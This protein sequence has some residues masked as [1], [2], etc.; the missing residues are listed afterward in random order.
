MPINKI[1]VPETFYNENIEEQE[2]MINYI[3]G[4]KTI[5]IYTSDNVTLTKLRKLI[6]AKGSLY[7]IK[8]IGY[9]D[10]K[11]CC[12]TVAAP[13]NCLSFR[14]GQKRDLTDEQREALANRMR[15]IGKARK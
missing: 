7:E 11:P 5:E 13:L 12:M 14:A 2:T 6:E 4:D 15:A 3:R 10:G 8:D 1:K 9:I